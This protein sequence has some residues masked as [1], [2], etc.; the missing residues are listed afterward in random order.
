MS[1]RNAPARTQQRYRMRNLLRRST[2]RRRKWFK[3]PP[4]TTLRTE[5]SPWQ[6]LR[7]RYATSMLQARLVWVRV[8]ASRCLSYLLD[9]LFKRKLGRCSLSVMSVPVSSRLVSPSLSQVPALCY[10]IWL[11]LSSLSD[12]PSSSL[13]I[14]ISLC[15]SR[16]LLTER[17]NTMLR[18]AHVGKTES[19]SAARR[20]LNLLRKFTARVPHPLSRLRRDFVFR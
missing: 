14:Y 16:C 13:Y 6:S 1:H 10:L 2:S 19:T 3:R 11:S 4:S 5:S 18:M 8:G 17:L 12:Y 20:P 7:E 9:A 15:M